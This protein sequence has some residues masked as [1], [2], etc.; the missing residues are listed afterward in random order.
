MANPK[1]KDGYHVEEYGVTERDP[2]TENSF[3]ILRVPKAV[4]EEVERRRQKIETEKHGEKISMRIMV[5][6]AADQMG[7]HI[8]HRHL[9]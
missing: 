2:K 1:L 6:C 5:M 8:P 3:R 4:M 7:N 9:I